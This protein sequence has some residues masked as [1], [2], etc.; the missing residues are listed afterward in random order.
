MLPP[1]QRRHRSEMQL[2]GIMPINSPVAPRSRCMRLNQCT[3]VRTYAAAARLI[4]RRSNGPVEPPGQ[5]P[6][7]NPPQ[8]CIGYSLDSAARKPARAANSRPWPSVGRVSPAGS[9]LVRQVPVDDPPPPG[10]R[11]PAVVASRLAV[12]FRTP[13][14]HQVRVEHINRAPFAVQT[15]STFVSGLNFLPLRRAG[16]VS[17]LCSCVSPLFNRRAAN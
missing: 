16:S 13:L 1:T 2:T 11:P 7:Q 4:H 15:K 17:S 12:P 8:T 3:T 10:G 14:F 6:N 5:I 9:A